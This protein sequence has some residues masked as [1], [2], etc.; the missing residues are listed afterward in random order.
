MMPDS[1]RSQWINRLCRAYAAMLYAYPRG[2]R[3]R[4]GREMQ[5][6]FRER[7]RAAAR[8][9]ELFVFVLRAFWDWLGASVREWLAAMRSPEVHAMQTACRGLVAAGF[10]RHRRRCVCGHAPFHAGLRWIVETSHIRVHHLG[11]VHGRAR[12]GSLRDCRWRLEFPKG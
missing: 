8:G 1:S 4:F 11:H 3:I 7:C 2:F 6:V 10:V 12:G 5:Q 9:R